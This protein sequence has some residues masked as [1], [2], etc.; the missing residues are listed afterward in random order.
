[1]TTLI[2]IERSRGSRAIHPSCF[3]LLLCSY[4]VACCLACSA[5]DHARDAPPDFGQ[6]VHEG[7]V[8]VP[9]LDVL[10]FQDTAPLLLSLQPGV[11]RGWRGVARGPAAPDSTPTD[12][13]VDR[14]GRYA[15]IISASG[16]RRTLA[17]HALFQDAV[18]AAAWRADF[19]GP[20]SAMSLPGERL[21]AFVAG[22]VERWLM[23]SPSGRSEIF[24]M[25]A[26]SSVWQRGE[27]LTVA[28]NGGRELIVLDGGAHDLDVLREH[29]LE[30][31]GLLA[32]HGSGLVGARLVDGT[33]TVARYNASFDVQATEDFWIGSGDL[34]QLVRL[35]QVADHTFR[36]AVLSSH[37]TRVTV[38]DIDEVA[39]RCAS[40]VVQERL[41]KLP[42]G[43]LRRDIVPVPQG[44]LLAG[45]SRLIRLRIGPEDEFFVAVDE[46]FD[47]AGLN[48]PLALMLVGEDPR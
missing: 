10:A 35:R 25:P 32:P 12:A 8:A 6:V 48:G 7:P 22:P 39:V 31:G 15:H 3:R 24:D 34:E 29:H 19:D 21:L 18:G 20:T 36:Y 28:A 42:A 17:S 30:H 16:T 33:M 27:E 11:G 1:M 23:L 26:P 44:I 47:G 40:V 46:A 41:G 43:S 38:L 45:A 37:P 9:P 14:M 13:V 5:G 4:L 2:F